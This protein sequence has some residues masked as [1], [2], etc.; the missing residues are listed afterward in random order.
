MRLVQLTDAGLVGSAGPR[1]EAAK[2]RRRT[3]NEQ[4][5][6]Q[7]DIC[8]GC[9]SPDFASRPAVMAPFIASYVLDRPPEVCALNACSACGLLFYAT[10][11]DEAEISRLYGD[12]RGERYLT[13]RHRFEPWYTRKINDDIGGLAG[14]EPRRELYRATLAAHAPD[15][16]VV[17]VLDYAGDH[18]QMMPG[19]PGREYYVYDVSGVTPAS[20]VT[21]IAEEDALAGRE[22]DLVLM[23]G[24]IEHFSEP[25][26]QLRRLSKHVKPGG[27]LYVAVPDER[28]RIEAI[29]KGQWYQNYLTHLVRGGLAMLALDFWSTA[30]RAKLRAIPPLGF[31]K[32][33][34]HLNYFDVDSLSHL[35]ST[36]G[37]TLLGCKSTNVDASVVALC[38]RPA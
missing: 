6:Y 11:Y 21:A 19:G 1:S 29:P 38:R 7:A 9:G 35:I 37:L 4:M 13:L 18:G 15:A 8:P 2:L 12:Y 24:V 16:P 10:R 22:F 27:L 20:G 5:T 14:I 36:A 31:A 30:V 32:Q 25:L 33:H 17:T 23:C 34:E 3:K 26:A 28:F